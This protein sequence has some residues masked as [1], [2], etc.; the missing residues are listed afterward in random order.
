MAAT[1]PSSSKPAGDDRNL[2]AVDAITAVTFEDKMQLFW[3]K[4]RTLVYG[5]VAV[6]VVAILAKGGL[7]AMAS[8]KEKDIETAYAAATTNDQLKAFVA[9]H[10][11][12]SLAGIAELR[13]ADEAYTAGKTADA[14]AGYDRAI[15]ILKTGPL[16]SRAKLGRA[17][18]KVQ[19]GKA[20][21]ATAELKQL[22]DDTSVSKGLRAEAAYQLTSLAV[23]AANATD[24][25]KY[26]DQLN[27]LDPM[28]P[29][30]Q[31]GAMLRATLPATP[32]PASAAPAAGEKKDES[33]VQ[34][35][36]P[37]ASK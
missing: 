6:I 18:A 7:E 16:A 17:L 1:P 12:H 19:S 4:N 11:S 32:A 30:A 24:A 25:Q 26:V 13:M 28:G 23:D 8:K 35:K 27:Q 37:A 36:L 5:A 29:W 2:V 33:G 31:R 10:G 9:S 3:K 20:S 22:A 21:E 34:L 14:I 15:G